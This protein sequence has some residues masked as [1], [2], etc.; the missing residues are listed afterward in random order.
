MAA[1]TRWSSCFAAVL[2]VVALAVT[3]RVS[4][5]QYV[6]PTTIILPGKFDPTM[7]KG[8]ETVLATRDWEGAPTARSYFEGAVALAPELQV[9]GGSADKSLAGSADLNRAGRALIGAHFMLGPEPPTS[10][11]EMIPC[12]P[13]LVTVSR[14]SRRVERPDGWVARTRPSSK[15]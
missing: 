14:T 5:A 1:Q 3:P 4:D 13:A 15:C 9:R 2:A 6:R 8:L 10:S 7:A 11:G 12:R